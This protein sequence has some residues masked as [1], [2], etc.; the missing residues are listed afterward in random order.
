MSDIQEPQSN[1][2]SRRTVTKSMAWA[3]PVIAL[4]SAVP[5]FAT[6]PEDVSV[7]IGPV[8]KYPGGSVG[9]ACKQDYRATMTFTNNN[10]NPLDVTTVSVLSATFGGTTMPL[11]GIFIT[12]TN[13][14]QSLEGF[15]FQLAVGAPKTYNF[16]FDS[17][18]SADLSGNFVVTFS[19]TVVT[20][21]SYTDTAS[22]FFSA[23]PPKCTLPDGSDAPCGG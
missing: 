6:S 20:G 11:S 18:N 23:T 13:P 17:K 19:Y 2:I 3:V 21:G 4:A 10:P 15:T 16:I 7:A 14:P 12:G 9:E 22:V 8:C 1:G 5:A